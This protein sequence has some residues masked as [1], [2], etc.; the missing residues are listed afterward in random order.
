MPSDINPDT[1]DA[2]YP[3]AGQD[4]STQ[5]FR[6]NFAA[7]KTNFQY[8]EQEI[9]E[10]ESNVLLKNGLGGGSVNNNLNDNLLYAARIQDFSWTKV[11]ATNTTGAIPLNYA[12]GHYQTIGSTTGSVSVS[13]IN[14]PATGNWGW[15]RLQVTV[16]NA[17]HTLTLPMTVTV[18]AQGIQGLDPAT[19]VITFAT[20]GTY[21]FDFETYTGGST[22]TVSETNKRLA[23]LNNSSEDLAPSAAVSLSTTTSYFSTAGAETATLAAGV[24]GQIKVFAMYAKVGNMVITVTNAGWKSTGTGTITFD[25]IGDACTLQYISGKWF[26]IGNNGAAFA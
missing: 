23:P 6:D 21:S 1:I 10:L 11:T 24:E 14:F 13:F 4:N 25:T 20:P 8:A 7:I 3:V 5:G 12:S 26:C 19:N 2:S 18:N 17:A 22:I 15:M 16:S 9:N